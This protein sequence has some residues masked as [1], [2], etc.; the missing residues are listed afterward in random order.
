MGCADL[1]DVTLP[2]DAGE[3]FDQRD[4]TSSSSRGLL[5]DNMFYWQRVGLY[6]TFVD[7]LSDFLS[8]SA[9]ARMPRSPGRHFLTTLDCVEKGNATC[10]PVGYSA[11]AFRKLHN[12]IDTNT[13]IDAG[14]N[15]WNG[16]FALS[17]LILE[18]N[19]QMNIGPN[20][21]SIRY[22]ETVVMTDGTSLGLPNF[23]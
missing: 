6:L 20:Q 17:D 12:G 9:C 23:E 5:N 21:A 11:T 3:C 22:V 18:I 1:H 4:N 14:G 15:F 13:T 10:A 7:F 8:E 19:H 16:A 2:A